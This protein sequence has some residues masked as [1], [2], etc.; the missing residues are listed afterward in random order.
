MM[1]YAHDRLGHAPDV[2]Q[3]AANNSLDSMGVCDRL[4]TVLAGLESAIEGASFIKGRVLSPL[5][6]VGSKTDSPIATPSPAN[7]EDMAHALGSRIVTLQLLLGEVAK[8][9]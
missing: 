3:R 5:T 9:L 4:L 6:G 8:G 2:G 7:L 1:E